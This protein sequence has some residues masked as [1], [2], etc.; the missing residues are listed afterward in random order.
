[1]NI[2]ALELAAVDGAELGEVTGG[3]SLPSPWQVFTFFY[4]EGYKIG[5]EVI[6][7]AIFG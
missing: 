3:S 7:P 1:M 2:A 5:Y 4:R 6:G